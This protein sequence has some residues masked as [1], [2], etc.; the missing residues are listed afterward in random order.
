MLCH[1]M[2]SAPRHEEMKQPRELGHDDEENCRQG[3]IKE[4]I[5]KEK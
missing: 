2:P 5:E 3:K 4:G 1:A